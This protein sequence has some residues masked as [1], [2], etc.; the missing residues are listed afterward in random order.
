MQAEANRVVVFHYRVSAGT[1][2]ASEHLDSSHDRGKPLAVL[3]GA[4]NVVPGVDKALVG[5]SPGDVFEL[6]LAPEDA[7]GERREGWVQRVPKKYFHPKAR[8]APGVITNLQM[9]DGG[10]R[11]VTV[12]K[13]GSSVVD[14]DLNPPMAGR[15]LHFE[16]EIV[17]VREATRE[18][19]AHRHAH[20]ANGHGHA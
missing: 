2:G 7:Y 12:L 17:D 1:G 14:V 3:V 19:I 13:V 8:L 6:D 9:R 10:R 18:E 11:Q 16:I 5:R 4:G 15:R 20:D